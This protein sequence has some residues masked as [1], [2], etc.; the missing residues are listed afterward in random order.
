[1]SEKQQFFFFFQFLWVTS[2]SMSD[3]GNWEWKGDG[4]GV[5][6]DLLNLPQ[7]RTRNGDNLAMEFGNQSITW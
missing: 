5:N 2:G 1:L 7:Q 6:R 4:S 3:S